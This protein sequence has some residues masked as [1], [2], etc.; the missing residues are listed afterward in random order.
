L[1]LRE[2]KRQSNLIDFQLVTNCFATAGNDS[3]LLCHL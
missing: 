3:L 2:A 1:S